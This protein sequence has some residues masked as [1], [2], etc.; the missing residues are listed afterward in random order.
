MKRKGSSSRFAIS[1]FRIRAPSSG[2]CPTGTEHTWPVPFGMM[3]P[4]KRSRRTVSKSTRN[5]WHVPYFGSMRIKSRLSS[6]L[7]ATLLACCRCPTFHRGQALCFWLSVQLRW[8]PPSVWLAFE[9]W[10]VMSILPTVVEIEI[11][12]KHTETVFQKVWILPATPEK[13]RGRSC[14]MVS[15]WRL[16][17]KRWKTTSLSWR[18]TLST[19]R[20]GRKSC[21]LGCMSLAV[22]YYSCIS[23][24]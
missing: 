21:W 6:S 15:S 11:E 3:R 24:G 16:Q 19:T 10:Y 8:L 14:S 1:G 17:S 22:S 9:F 7:A 13:L 12:V 4:K 5:L 20:R 23:K 18:T 2:S